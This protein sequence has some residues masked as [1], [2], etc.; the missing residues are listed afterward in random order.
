MMTSTTV[1]AVVRIII[2]R[3]H[4][5]QLLYNTTACNYMTGPDDDQSGHARQTYNNAPASGDGDGG[6]GMVNTIAKSPAE[7]PGILS[8]DAIISVD[9]ME[10]I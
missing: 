6:V 10:S 4:Q 7:N 8:G 9:A 2:L 3:C 5:Q 1:P